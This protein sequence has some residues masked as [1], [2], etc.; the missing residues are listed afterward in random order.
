MANISGD[1]IKV[2]G[3]TFGK[4]DHCWLAQS[5]P[6]EY[7]ET[8][9]CCGCGASM[10]PCFQISNSAGALG[11]VTSICQRCGFVKKTSQLGGQYISQ[12][13]AKRW[14]IR[15]D[16]VLR[17]SLYPYTKLAPLVK[18]GGR[19]LDLGCGIG[20]RLLPF[21]NN[22]FDVYGVD[23]SEHRTQI[24]TT[25]MRN[26]LVGDGETYLANNHEK[27]D[28]IYLF[29]V[30]QFLVNPFAVIQAALEHV[31]DGGFLFF[32]VSNFQEH[33]MVQLAHLGVIVSYLSPY[34]VGRFLQTSNL[35]S[36]VVEY[37]HSPFECI[38]RKGKGAQ[39]NQNMH[40]ASPCQ[41][42]N[43]VDSARTSSVYSRFPYMVRR[44][45]ELNSPGR[46]IEFHRRFIRKIK[47]PLTFMYDT[48]YIP[49]LLK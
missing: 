28:L 12:H 9:Y 15:R 44:S 29:N 39:G 17:E 16:D 6:D 2:R 21:H 48:E 41:L 25:R 13:F 43:I 1:I 7:Y 14:L 36:C 30:L 49:V 11:C 3:W 37:S 42:T 8:P 38:I 27:F 32:S 20:D 4:E 33:N 45:V 47:A 23:P 31:V 10:T 46:T 19:V 35:D 22:G 26:I 24:A 34:S 18:A 5:W 40:Q